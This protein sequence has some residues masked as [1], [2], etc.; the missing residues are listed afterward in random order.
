VE[1]GRALPVDRLCPLRLAALSG[2]RPQ[3]RAANPDH[4]LELRQRAPDSERRRRRAR[5]TVKQI[6]ATLRNGNQ[7]VLVLD[8]PDAD[9]ERLFGE[10]GAGRSQALRG[11]VSV[12]PLG[13]G[14]KI[15]V[16][17]DEIVELQLIDTDA[18]FEGPAAD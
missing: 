15:V 3:A 11:W 16:Q 7:Y 4:V 18:S 13:S 10:V 14:E 8:G 17:G 6:R 1:A 9:A 5:W 2:H 12:E